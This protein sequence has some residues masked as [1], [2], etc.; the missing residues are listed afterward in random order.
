MAAGDLVV[1]NRQ[2]EFRGLLV[3]SQTLYNVVQIEGLLASQQSRVDAL[4]RGDDHGAYLGRL[5]LN[6]RIITMELD[7]YSEAVNSQEDL[8]AKLDALALAYQPRDTDDMFVFQRPG[9]S[10]RFVYAR[11]TRSGFTANYRSYKGVAGGAVEFFC[12]DP[13]IYA[14]TVDSTTI[15]LAGVASNSGTVTN[16]GSF[17]NQPTLE[18]TG[19]ATNPRVANA[20]DSN[21][22]IKL[23]GILASGDTLIIDLRTK[24]VTINGVNRFDMVRSDSQW[25]QLLPGANSITMNRDQTTGTAQLVV[26][27]RNTYL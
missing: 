20:A 12:A 16:A 26:R 14:W 7:V 5:L 23:D 11:S 18:I 9:Q 21:R 22:S 2:Y 13:R 17:A 27:K 3:G 15:T 8:E 4:S 1:A 6:P 10:K 19:P 24:T 25:W